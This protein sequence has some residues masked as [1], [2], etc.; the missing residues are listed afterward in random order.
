MTMPVTKNFGDFLDLYGS[1]AGEDLGESDDEST[2]DGEGGDD[3]GAGERRPLLARSS[4]SK[5]FS[6][7]GDASNVKTFFTLIKGFVGTGIMFLPKAFRN[8]GL[9]FSTV[10][11][12]TVSIATAI[13]FHL[14]LECR[15]KVG[16]GYG[17]IG[18]RISG[19][20]LRQLILVS[21]TVSQL[22]F[23]SSGI[24][25]TAE[26]LYSFAE[27]VAR[28]PSF[29]P[30]AYTLIALQL[31]CLVPLSYIR[32]LSKLGPLALLADVFIL[33]GLTYIYSYD[34]ATLASVRGASPTVRLFNP[35]DF[36]LTIGSAIFT[37]EGIGLI[38]PIQ[39]SMRRP[40]SFDALLYS[41]MAIITV[42]FTTVGAL[43]YATFGEETKTEIITNFPQDSKLVNAVQFLY[44]LAVLVGTPMQFFPAV[45]IMESKVFGRRTG[46]RDRSTKWLKNAFRTVIML[47]CGV[48]AAVG[49]GDLD[50]F[51][52]L[53]G[54]F[55]VSPQLFPSAAERP[56]PFVG[57]PALAS[58]I[59]PPFPFRPIRL[60]ASG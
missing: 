54:S 47:L 10:T 24:I 46:K 40:Q 36:T 52:A 34:I 43:S 21:I 11:M 51:V 31:V 55:A 22:G 9:L 59:I 4:T 44:S 37:F 42:I 49:A 60:S 58:D 30:S 19:P 28:D 45:R 13:C 25:F 5:R 38:L 18:E 7:R 50:K 20:R 1:F 41:V 14:L 8:G 33:V 39:A 53:I 16:G 6:E 26:N 48:I 35:R 57:G 2:P 17:D 29:L 12:L 3:E 56:V 27:A 32:N 15:R 23:V